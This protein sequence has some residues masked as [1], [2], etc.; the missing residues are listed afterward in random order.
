MKGTISLADELRA[1]RGGNNSKTS[2]KHSVEVEDRRA[3]WLADIERMENSLQDVL[4]AISQLS[5]VELPGV[6]ETSDNGKGESLARADCTTLKDR[7]RNDLEAF[8]MQA[9]ADVARQAEE[10]TR[11]ALAAIRDEVSGQVSQVTSEF[12]EKLH[13][14]F[15]REHFGT[16]LA[17]RS[18]DRVAQLVDAQT[19]EF[20]RW[21]WLTCKGTGTSIP[22][23]IEKLL[24]PYV[25]EATA[26][27]TESFQQKVQDLFA[28][29]ERL[30]QEKL[31]TAIQSVETQVGSLEH[32]SL[33]VCEQNADQVVKK[34]VER[35]QFSADKALKGLEGRF[36][37]EIEGAIGR[38]QARLAENSE[39]AQ[40]NLQED[41]EQKVQSFRQRLE[42]VTAEVQDTRIA[43]ISGRITQTAA[44]VVESSV[45]HLHH[46]AE[47]SLEHS[48]EEISAYMKLQTEEVR[49]QIQ[50]L[51]LTAQ[52]SVAEDSDR[53][54]E[55]LRKV[56]NELSAVCERQISASREQLTN[57]V[58]EIM[59]S[60][61]E[62]IRQLGNQQMDEVKRFV[63]D[64]HDTAASEYTT[65]LKEA[66]ES[67]FNEVMERIRQEA[68]D[69]GS[70][71]AAQLSTT[72]EAMIRELS[73]KVNASA[74]AL[75][76]E[77]AQATLRI[78]TAVKL[79]L[80]A[81][82][83]Q[84][85]EITND[86]L[87][88]QRTAMKGNIAELHNRLIQAAELLSQG[89]LVTK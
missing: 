7:I 44:D 25:E 65:H 38:F 76:E 20:A 12:Q 24:E 50:D 58:Q 22:A 89:D 66:T 34:T 46:Q 57:A 31:Q 48:R 18:K 69:A 84:L 75:R 64:S 43:E 6:S 5:G 72:S 82:R 63:Q 33:Q 80:E 14:Q 62:H 85:D 60:M 54:A 42:S 30:S 77:A 16:E 74:A 17:E 11:A 61:T 53:V 2:F 40:K 9:A 67:R 41:H 45:Q 86:G 4:R 23:H 37:A 56:D 88:E 27:F 1:I 83:Q 59:G 70:R 52:Q 81:Y 55:R 47:D 19:E 68:G 78:E 15:E 13:G 79:S 51:C 71:V 10:Q 3:P 35:L 73:D 39:A 28:E 8:S 87:N 32:A 26:K 29:Q 21:V 49:H 36:D